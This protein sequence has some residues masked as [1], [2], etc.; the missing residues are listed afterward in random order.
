MRTIRK[1]FLAGFLAVVGL[2]LGVKTFIALGTDANAKPTPFEEAGKQLAKT[3]NKI[4]TT[5]TE[6]Q[7]QSQAVTKEP[8]AKG[9]LK[10]ISNMDKKR[11]DLIALREE[12]MKDVD[13]F[14]QTC[15]TT[16]T[17]ADQETQRIRDRITRRQMERR[18]Q[19]IHADA[20]KRSII[21]RNTIE[22]VNIALARMEDLQHVK[23]VLMAI[24]TMTRGIQDL[25]DQVNRA[26]Q[27][28]EEL[29]KS[30]TELLAGLA[31]PDNAPDNIPAGS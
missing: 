20:M 16:A 27:T 15:Q 12:L 9:I 22:S 23:A 26:Q 31:E 5:V 21:A 18:F 13:A 4:S 1:A 2:T 8:D 7:K 3:E 6:I 28:A 29:S 30:T 24:D 11:D 14:D 10:D 17:E 19:R 25:S